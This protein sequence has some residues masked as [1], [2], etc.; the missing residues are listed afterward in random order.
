MRFFGQ[1]VP[2]WRPLIAFSVAYCMAQW[3]V[4]WSAGPVARYAMLAAMS[5]VLFFAMTLNVIYGLRTFAKDFYG[6]MIFFAFVIGGICVLNALK[7]L[8]IMDSGLEALH[9]ESRF[10]MVFYIYM[11]TLATVLPPSIVWLVLRRLT[12]DLRTMAAR[13]PMTHLLNQKRCSCTSTAA[14]LRRHACY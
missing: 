11:S 10:Q 13:D 9:M 8:K 7:F 3:L 12:D 6:E 2:V 4:H 14:T 5:A 1:P